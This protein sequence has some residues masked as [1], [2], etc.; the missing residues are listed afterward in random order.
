MY[1][2]F[3]FNGSIG[4]CIG[5]NHIIYVL[6]M[7]DLMKELDKGHYIQGV[8]YDNNKKVVYKTHTELE[9]KCEGILHK[10]CNILLNIGE[11][12]DLPF[13]EDTSLH[14]DVGFRDTLHG[15]YILELVDTKRKISVNISLFSILKGVV[16]QIEVA[17]DFDKVHS[18]C[19]S[20]T[21]SNESYQLT[22]E[23][24]NNIGTFLEQYIL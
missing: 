14:F 23:D 24:I 18:L 3:Y 4:Y 8:G 16:V 1:N 10:I 17:E 21:S 15:D 13:V 19:F 11:C 5:A 12:S 20:T 9:K 7:E 6:S 2:C 22:E